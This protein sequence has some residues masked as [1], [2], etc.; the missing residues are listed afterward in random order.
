[1]EKD[2]TITQDTLLE[3]INLMK[4]VQEERD[5]VLKAAFILWLKSIEQKDAAKEVEKKGLPT[6]IFTSSDIYPVCSQLMAR[7]V[8]VVE[9]KYIETKYTVMLAWGELYRITYSPAI[10][11]KKYTVYAD[12]LK[13]AIDNAQNAHER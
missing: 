2:S 9:N 6:H 7:Y 11:G 3:C 12:Q 4:K 13:R 5:D 10:D 8:E 1:M